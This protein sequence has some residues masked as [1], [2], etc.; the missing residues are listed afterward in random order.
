MF[1]MQT[2]VA[3]ASEETQSNDMRI[4]MYAAVASILATV[5]GLLLMRAASIHTAAVALLVMGIGPV[6]GYALATNSIVKSILAM[7]LGGLSSLIGVMVAPFIIWPILVGATLKQV[8]M[9]KLLLWSVIAEIV[10]VLII[11]VIIIPTM[12]QNPSWLQ[13]ALLVGG[14]SWGLGVSYGL[15]K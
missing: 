15:S 5:I 12:G 14:I 11:L 6:L 13:T 1:S 9:G 3:D 7:V 10:G 4:L 8:S 2:V